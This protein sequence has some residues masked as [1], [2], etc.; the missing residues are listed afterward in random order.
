MTRTLQME[1]K[2]IDEA[3]RVMIPEYIVGKMI[4]GHKLNESE[5]E[6]VR[7]FGK[8]YVEAHKKDDK[9]VK[10][11][12]RN[13]PKSL[14]RE[15]PDVETHITWTHGDTHT[16]IINHKKKEWKITHKGKLAG[17]KGTTPGMEQI[18][19]RA[20]ALEYKQITNYR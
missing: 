10:Q 14:L 13:L 9:W 20:G 17:F 19:R 2:E 6:I 5:K 3:R 15:K 4:W 1:Q 7:R 12:L 18:L 11:H 8:V 16:M